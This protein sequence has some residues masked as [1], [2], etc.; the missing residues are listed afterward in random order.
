MSQQNATEKIKELIGW[1]AGTHIV[2]GLG[3]WLK[4]LVPDDDDFEQS[5]YL[6]DR[7][8][9]AA[10]YLSEA[11]DEEKSQAVKS[12]HKWCVESGLS[13]TRNSLCHD[14]DMNGFETL[15]VAAIIHHPELLIF[16]KDKAFEEFRSTAIAA[17]DGKFD[18]SDE[19]RDE[20]LR[21]V[22]LTQIPN[23][24]GEIEAEQ[25]EFF[26]PRKETSETIRRLKSTKSYLTTVV[27]D[28]GAGKTKL[29]I[30]VLSKFAN[31]SEESNFDGI[32][33]VSG[34][35]EEISDEGYV[36][37]LS[38]GFTDVESLK[39][40]ILFA[41]GESD[42]DE[43]VS[44]S[45][46]LCIDNAE[47][48]IV[49]SQSD[50]EDFLESLPDSW[51]V[52]VTS[53]QVG[54]K[55]SSTQV[56]KL[57]MDSN[58]IKGVVNEYAKRRDLRIDTGTFNV[59]T[60]ASQTPLE[61]KLI[62]DLACQ[63]GIS[64]MQ[65]LVAKARNITSNYC[66]EKLANSISDIQKK[67]VEFCFIEDGVSVPRLRSIWPELDE[68]SL[69][70]AIRGLSDS[71][72]LAPGNK[73]TESFRSYLSVNAVDPESRNFINSELEEQKKLSGSLTASVYYCEALGLKELPSEFVENWLLLE[74]LERQKSSVQVREILQRI[75]EEF[76]FAL[77][78][79]AY[80]DRVKSMI[81]YGVFRAFKALRKWDEATLHL[82]KACQS[83]EPFLPAVCSKVED[84]RERNDNFGI[85]NTA[86]PYARQIL[87]DDF[88]LS[89]LDQSLRERLRDI[90][91]EY[92]LARL[93]QTSDK[94]EFAQ[95]AFHEIRDE[96]SQLITDAH[97][98]F[99]VPI[100]VLQAQVSARLVSHASGRSSNSRSRYLPEHSVILRDA[101]HNLINDASSEDY[102]VV[103]AGPKVRKNFLSTLDRLLG[104]I[105]P[106]TNTSFHSPDEVAKNKQAIVDLL[107]FFLPLFDST[108]KSCRGEWLTKI[109]SR[110]DRINLSPDP[111]KGTSFEAQDLTEL[112]DRGYIK[113]VV[114]RGSRPDQGFYFVQLPNRA[115]LYVSLN[116]VGSSEPME[117][118]DSV[119]V[120]ITEQS[121]ECID[122]H[123]V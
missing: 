57:Q 21:I 17:I 63:T 44:R 107:N 123:K 43:I 87:K 5:Q 104:E 120:L 100:K 25:V 84:L 90:P 68:E 71:M 79:H 10:Q 99:L 97:P 54:L 49:S 7:F 56:V 89:G 112:H 32:Y 115:D 40:S 45:I 111:F 95:E 91:F 101:I 51:K 102:V 27:A 108:L 6:D 81:N 98:S 35:Q 64:E 20:Y 36:R 106:F 13:G 39:E 96:L 46:L 122:C 65:D 48:I 53:R 47:E 37:E 73:L 92:Y 118:G 109:L 3:R 119:M 42:W 121:D 85:V 28:G 31:R 60:E 113:G 30:E 19:K 88:D 22:G 93:Y 59:I 66:Y 15:C 34:K 82:N 11:G 75:A 62:I 77:S 38:A 116:V 26:I 94:T 72:L 61:A 86:Q 2:I 80:P 117:P 110:L 16:S 9:A 24:L 83:S 58:V 14:R 70:I 1:K 52:L 41:S 76:V 50:L 4:S 74:R 12:L 8:T 33:F 18:I 55:L 105:A 29:A 78:S 114:K 69:H 67:V 23:N 103:S